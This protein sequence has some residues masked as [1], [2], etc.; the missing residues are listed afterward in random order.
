MIVR[1]WHGRTPRARADAYAN[2]L[3]ARAVPDYRSVPGNL[4]VLVVRRDEG[5][6]TH[7]L[8]ITRWE[9]EASIQAFAGS[10]LLKAKYYPEDAEYLL[11]FEEHV[12]HFAVVA[13][14]GAAART[15]LDR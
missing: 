8:T 5:N 12:Q 14:A 6:I 10:N 4:E 2:F 9:S 11:E 1:I 7:F 15:E 3:E 13:A